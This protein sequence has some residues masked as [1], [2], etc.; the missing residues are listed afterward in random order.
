MSSNSP[1]GGETGPAPPR[2]LV[3]DDEAS[4]GRFLKVALPMWGIEEIEWVAS[5]AEGV[6]RCS[7]ARPDVVLLDYLL[8]N[9]NG[10]EVA[11]QLRSFCPG[12]RIIAF[13][14]FLMEKPPW[15]DDFFPKADLFRLE[16]LAEVVRGR[17]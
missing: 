1:T 10:A 9:E 2:V 17:N 4:L 5:G 3:I 16:R 14:G 11:D 8:V 15:A 12:V 7:R 6:E 13:S